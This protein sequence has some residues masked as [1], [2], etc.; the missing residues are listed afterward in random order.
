MTYL[1]TVVVLILAVVCG[2]AIRRTS[3]GVP[4][5]VKRRVSK[6]HEHPETLAQLRD[7]Y[8]DGAGL[9]HGSEACWV[10]FEAEVVSRKTN[11]NSP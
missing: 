2:I 5:N 7:A 4:R 3:P 1:L 6:P 11:G 10:R 8:A 9:T